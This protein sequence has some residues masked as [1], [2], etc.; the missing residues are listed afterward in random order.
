MDWGFLGDLGSAALGGYAVYQQ[1]KGQDEYYDSLDRADRD[2]QQLDQDKY[3]YDLKVAA[4]MQ[5]GGGG[6][7]GG[8]GGSSGPK[9]TQD[10]LNIYQDYMNRAQNLYQPYIDAAKP[11]IPK[12]ADAYGKGIDSAVSMLDA[13]STP[14]M[15]NRMFQSVPAA[16]IE[17]QFPKVRR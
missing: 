2:K 7:G 5:S 16:N 1:Q 6:G 15:K 10:M 17:F 9:Y 14:E 13:Y 12:A 8:G 3:N 11:L 4:L